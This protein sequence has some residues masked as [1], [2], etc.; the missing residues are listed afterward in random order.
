LSGPDRYHLDDGRIVTANSCRRFITVDLAV[1]QKQSADYTVAA[2]WAIT[3]TRELIL[4]DRIR[5]RI[6]GP[7]QVPLLRRLHEQWAPDII[8]IEA[9]AYQLAII[10]QARRDGLPITELKPDRDKVSRALVA[11]ARLEGGTIDWPRTAPWLHEWE[12]ELLLF[13]NAR[14]DDQV[15][16]LAYAAIEL[17]KRNRID[18]IA[19]GRAIARANADLFRPSSLDRIQSTDQAVAWSPRRAHIAGHGRAVLW[20][21]CSCE[22]PSTYLRPP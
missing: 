4:L 10:Q 5:Q 18:H 11:A 20:V 8:G 7:D 9:V 1:S 17:T 15:D 12:N 21:S 3:N 14:H 13:P 6:P 16:T 19:I 22:S 2:I